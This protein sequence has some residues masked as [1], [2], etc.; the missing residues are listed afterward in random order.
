MGENIGV[1]DPYSF[2]EDAGNDILR[3]LLQSRGT[4]KTYFAGRDKRPNL[5]D[6]FELLTSDNEKGLPAPI[7]RIEVQIKTM[8]RDYTNG[9]TRGK[10]SKYKY[11]C[12][13]KVINAVLRP[14]THNPVFLL[15]V[16][17]VGQRC[18]YI[19][20]S[21]E[22]LIQLGTVGETATF[23]FNDENEINLETLAVFHSKAKAI[24]DSYD[25]KVSNGTANMVTASDMLSNVIIQKLQQSVDRFNSLMDNELSFIKFHIFPNVWKFGLAYSVDENDIVVGIYT[26]R[27]GENGAFIKEYNFDRDKSSI[28]ISRLQNIDIDQINRVVN[29]FVIG[30][31]QDYFKHRTI[32]IQYLPDVALEELVFSFLDEL[33]HYNDC[34]QKKIYPHIYYNDDEAVSVVERLWNALIALSC[35]LA[36]KYGLVN[37]N[38]AVVDPLTFFNTGMGDG[39]M[40]YARRR[41][42]EIYQNEEPFQESQFLCCFN[43]RFPY[44]MLKSAITELKSRQIERVRRPWKHKDYENFMQDIEHLTGLQRI[45]TGF[46]VNDYID[47]LLKIF[48]ILPDYYDSVSSGMFGRY[49]EEMR[50]KRHY[51]IGIKSDG[52]FSF[53]HASCPADA[54]IV[55]VEITNMPDSQSFKERFLNIDEYGSGKVYSLFQSYTPLYDSI[56]TV[57]HKSICQHLGIRELL[58][59]YTVGP[60]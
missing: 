24:F 9:N 28:Y 37:G 35:E 7:G 32:D 55:D 57:I 1:Y 21:D 31:E 30:I 18:F 19:H 45:E 53:F 51:Y 8:E 6:Y 17:I 25:R 27:Q 23:Y 54:F 2:N 58:K 36:E 20:I 44:G 42:I 3:S 14:I 5:D 56:V 40:N 22:L 39:S 26:I 41:L 60:I 38:R 11:S 34:F 59:G 43:G 15:L 33:S 48:S 46:R 47:N 12:D 4:I 13:T 52:T 50:L 49:H 10:R 29:D 16:D